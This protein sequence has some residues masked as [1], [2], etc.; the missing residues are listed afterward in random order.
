MISKDN[1]FFGLLSLLLE[2]ED[3]LILSRTLWVAMKQK[4]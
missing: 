3:V 4:F 2:D 1:T